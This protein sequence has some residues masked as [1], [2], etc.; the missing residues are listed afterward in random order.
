MKTVAI[1]TRVHPDRPSML[2]VCVESVTG[3]T[4]D[5]YVH[6][7]HRHDKSSRG[8]GRHEA[9][10]SI[11]A[12]K[13]IPARYAMVLDDDDCLVDPDFVKDFKAQVESNPEIVFFKGQIHHHGILP[14]PEQWGR[15][16]V[17]AGIGSFCFAVR[18]D[19]WFKHIRHFDRE[20]CGDFFFLDACWK[21][22]TR[23]VWW[24]RLVAKTQKG[25]GFGMAEKEHA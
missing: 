10:R 20:R 21:N 2:K 14:R 8:Y 7:L 24:D 15:R 25:P 16:P 5:D 3:Q 1:I 19:V 9:N 17:L 23:H 18:T 11:I 6:I 12:V 22:T 4:D 13:E